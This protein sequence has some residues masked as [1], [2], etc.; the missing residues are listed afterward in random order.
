MAT[1]ADQTVGSNPY[2]L[3]ADLFTGKEIIQRGEAMVRLHLEKLQAEKEDS[4][5]R[6]ITA[7][8]PQMG[9]PILVASL[10]EC[11]F[12]V[13]GAVALL[14]KFSSEYEEDLKALHKKRSKI[15]AQAREAAEKEEAAEGSS[16]SSSDDNS[17]DGESSD[18][19]D[20]GHKQRKKRR[21]EKTKKSKHSSK[22]DKK[23]KKKKKD[24]GRLLDR[25]SKSGNAGDNFGKYGVI[26]ETDAAAKS[27]EFILWALEVKK[28]DLETLP[29]NDEREL[30][31]DYIEEY[32]TASFP[33][34]KYY[35]LESYEKYKAAKRA[36][37]GIKESDKKSAVDDEQ[38]LR[39]ARAE[40]AAKLRDQ[41]LKEA[42]QELKHSDKAKDMKEQELLRLQ[43]QTA[44]RVGDKALAQKIM[45]RLL[46][47]DQKPA[48]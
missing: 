38:A 39:Q 9:A 7:L 30:F 20:Q 45:E 44:Y 40:E 12:D 14:K 13:E 41:R 34:R 28:V 31:R 25:K 3:D 32:N 43:M 17:D 27:S 6:L 22:K 5:L 8:M 2:G 47:D 42:Y 26:R 46:P 23:K 11:S 24:D 33:H 15:K 19:S 16:S 1:A 35:N 10:K 21:K 18:D 37:K 48:K 4:A 36:A 29:K